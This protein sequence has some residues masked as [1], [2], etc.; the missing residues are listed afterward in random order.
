MD[1]RDIS[2]WYAVAVLTV[3]AGS[4]YLMHNIFLIAERHEESYAKPA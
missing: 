3:P 2:F 4:A 1:R